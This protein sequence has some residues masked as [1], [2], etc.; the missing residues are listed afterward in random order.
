MKQTLIF[1][2]QEPDLESGI[3]AVS[4]VSCA[5]GSDIANEE[6]ESKF[7][8]ICLLMITIVYFCILLLTSVYYCLLFIYFLFTFVYL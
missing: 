2:G 7:V 1:S 3:G 8:Y 5:V 4:F 6:D